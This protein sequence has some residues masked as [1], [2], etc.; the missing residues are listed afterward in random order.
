MVPA[1]E[2]AK[3]LTVAIGDAL[4]ITLQR[5]CSPYFNR[6]EVKDGKYLIIPT[7]EDRSAKRAIDLLEITVDVGYQ[8]ALPDPTE[9]NPDPSNNLTWAD[10]QLEKVQAIKELFEDE[11]D[12]RDADFAGATFVRMTNTPLFRPDLMRDNEIFTSVIRFE[13]RAQA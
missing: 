13:F 11:G 1:V 4:S 5:R 6:E 10:A 7:G 8:I 9:A 2:I 3:A 12:L